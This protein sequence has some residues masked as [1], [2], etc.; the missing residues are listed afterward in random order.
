MTLA[1]SLRKAVSRDDLLSKP[2]L[3][4]TQLDMLASAVSSIDGDTW[5]KSD[6]R[7]ESRWCEGPAFTAAELNFRQKIKSRIDLPVSEVVEAAVARVQAE[8]AGGYELNVDEEKPRGQSRHRRSEDVVVTLAE[9]AAE[10]MCPDYQPVLVEQPVRIELPNNTHDLYGV[11]DLADDRGRV[12]DTKTAAKSKSRTTRIRRSNSRHTRR[13]TR[14]RPV[15][16]RPNCG[17]KCSS[18]QRRRSVETLVTTRSEGGPGGAGGSESMRQ[19]N[20]SG[21]RVHAS[22]AGA[23]WCGPKLVW[24]WAS[25]PFVNRGRAPQGLRWRRVSWWTRRSM[26]RRICLATLLS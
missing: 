10:E 11:I 20:H 7:P 12:V 2:H 3:S 14:W 24:L 22:D 26:R 8:L 25:C 23:W 17:W 15:S 9:L 6:A 13:C 16:S 19:S 4:P 5:N 18:A 1:L 21:G